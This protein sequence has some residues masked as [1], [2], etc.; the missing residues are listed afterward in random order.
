MH[1]SLSLVRWQSSKE[2]FYSSFYDVLMRL[3]KTGPHSVYYW[4]TTYHTF[5]S[6]AAWFVIIVFFFFVKFSCSNMEMYIY[7][8]PQTDVVQV[9]DICMRGLILYMNYI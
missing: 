3:P 8:R 2:W 4:L 7:C 1:L 6:H 5:G 9:H